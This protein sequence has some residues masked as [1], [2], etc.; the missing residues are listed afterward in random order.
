M[1]ARRPLAL[2]L[3]A[4]LLATG[5]GGCV[6]AVIPVG[7]AALLGKKELDRRTR[8]KRNPAVTDKAIADHASADQAGADTGKPA[9]GLATAEARAMMEGLG[10]DS[11]G[12]G[13]AGGGDVKIVSADAFDP[14]AVAVPPISEAPPALGFAGFDVRAP[15]NAAR[16]ADYWTA[17]FKPGV[18]PTSG[19]V[20][21]SPFGT[22]AK[23]DFTICENMPPALL[24]DLD[25]TTETSVPV[26]D[27]LIELFDGIREKGGKVIFVASVP[28]KDANMVATDLVVAGLGPAKR[29]DSFYLVG[30]RQSTSKDTL[31][32]KIASSNCIVAMAGDRYED[33]SD[34]LTP[35]LARNRGQIG[36]PVQKLAGAG[37][38][39]LPE[40]RASL[41]GDRP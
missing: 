29:N 22:M 36:A 16:V 12:K 4:A 3:V 5:L 39:I 28:E 8:Y 20:V 17:K 38:F 30:D 31:R 33:F 11:A 25:G 35:A 2:T 32:W 26:S 27:A 10:G 23:P 13:G 18:K 34:Q 1:M 24:V 14:R 41:A 9:A 40:L 15:D 6:A 37:W 7:A 19:S 21:L